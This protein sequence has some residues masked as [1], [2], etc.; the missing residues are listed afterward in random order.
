MIAALDSSFDAPSADQ[1]RAAAAAGIRGWCGYIATRGGTGLAA[2]WTRLAFEN[3]RLCGGTPIGFCSGQDDPVAVGRLAAAWNVL[4][5]LDVEPGIRADGPWVQGWLDAS[6]AGLYGLASVHFATGGRRAAGHIVANYPGR[7]PRA[8]WPPW[9]PRPPGPLGWQWQGT[10]QEFGRSV[11]RL[12]LDD[13]FAEGDLNVAQLDDIL[14]LLLFGE[15]PAYADPSGN[16][17]GWSAPEG[18]GHL[19]RATEAVMAGQGA[20]LNAL[21]V[22]KTEVDA[23]LAGIRTPAPVDVSALAAALAAHL[24]PAVDVHALA[25]ELEAVLP[26]ADAEAIK[27]ALAQALAK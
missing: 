26:G 21:G 10:H 5:Y 25:L 4:P 2:P 15:A 7:D 11:D 3:A 8:T 12:W 13:V 22:E 19:T 24:P 9:L 16:P 18:K 1:A 6:G 23:V 20:A 14:R 17:Y 27:A